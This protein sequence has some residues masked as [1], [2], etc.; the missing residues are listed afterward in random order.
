M[1]SFASMIVASCLAFAGSAL[2]QGGSNAA[3]TAPA[4]NAT[5]PGERMICRSERVTGTRN[6]KRICRTAEQIEAEKKAAQE[7]TRD[8]QRQTSAEAGGN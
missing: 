8:G 7:L 1:K 4:A 3:E 5:S 2:A 6:T